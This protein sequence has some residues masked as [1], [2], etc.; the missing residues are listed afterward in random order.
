MDLQFETENAFVGEDHSWLK[1]RLGF[2]TARTITLDLSLFDADDD[3]PN[4]FIPSGKMVAK[5]GTGLYGPYDNSLGGAATD[6][7]QSLTRT[8]T[9]GTI[10]LTVD[11]FDPTDDIPASAAGFTA[12]AVQAALLAVDGIEAGDITVTGP[13]GGP[14]V[15]TFGGQF[16]SENVPQVTV[17]NTD[18]TGGTVTAGTTTQGVTGQGIAAGHLLNSVSVRPTNANGR[19]VT[20][21]LWQG[22]VKRNRLPAN[23]G[24]DVAAEADLIH[25]RYED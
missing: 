8:S 12:A 13:A 4:G 2:D 21:L 1:S 20:A 9:G 10:T 23:S 16:D 6:E 18:A 17:D 19:A 5:L 3:Y 14:L 24:Y 25:I 15:L 11:G 22:I 7:V